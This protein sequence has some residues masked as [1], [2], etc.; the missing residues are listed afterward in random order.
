MKQLLIVET[1]D[2][3]EHRGPARMAELAIGMVQAGVRATVFLT[4]NGAFSARKK[5]A[6][7]AARALAGGVS[8]AVDR[9][10]LQ[11]RAIDESELESGIAPSDVDL[12]VEHLS[13][14]GCVIW[15]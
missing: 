4:E 8:I 2:A 13:A 3:A 10:A 11:E 7:F 6:G 5:P 15:R 1:R 9:F 12:I 14:G